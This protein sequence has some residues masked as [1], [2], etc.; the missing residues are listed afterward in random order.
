MASSHD[1][2]SPPLLHVDGRYCPEDGAGGI[3]FFSLLFLAVNA[4]FATG[5][6]AK[7]I[8]SPIVGGGF[9]FIVVHQH[10]CFVLDSS[11]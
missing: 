6:T 2:V 3:K 11:F 9:L 1:H 7:K 5:G 8:S 4:I 10:F